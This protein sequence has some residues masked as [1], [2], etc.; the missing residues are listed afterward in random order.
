MKLKFESKIVL[1]KT[2]IADKELKFQLCRVA[3]RIL[4]YLSILINIWFQ[5]LHMNKDKSFSSFKIDE[6][7]D[8][9][10]QENY[11]AHNSVPD[12]TLK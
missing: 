9:L 5:Y 10:L 3:A 8:N 6:S 11:S 7:L 4:S 12:I 1:K 2:N